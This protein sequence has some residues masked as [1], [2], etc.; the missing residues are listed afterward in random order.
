MMNVRQMEVF[1]AIMVTGSVTGAA[2]LLNV[3]QPAVS[4][5]LKHCESRLK[6]K[7]FNRVGGRLQPTNEAKAI[8]PDVAEIFGRIEAVGR[9]TQDLVGGRLGTLSV[10]AAFP[11]ANSYL[12]KAVAT[13]V[14]SRPQVRCTLQSLP[15]PQVLDRVI[16]RQ[17]EIGVGHEPIISAAVETEVLMSW[18][19]ACVMPENHPLATRSEIY[20]KDLATYPIITYL[21]QYVF[22]P[23]I[24]RALSDAGIAPN[25]VVQ[26]GVSLTGVMLARFGAGIALV[27]PLLVNVMG[28][29]G[30]V[31]RELKPR[32]GT[33][34]LLIRP[35]AAPQSVVVNDFIAHLRQTIRNEQLALKAL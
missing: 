4:T 16:N 8:F 14:A 24:D 21:P 18:S 30:L 25:I 13:F 19:V 26:V 28:I 35:K 9:L 10:A 15:T 2:Q 34:V 6:M 1:Y 12:A 22:R 17:I 11:I 31:V 32:I 23:Y 20:I 33:K 27:D 5:A 7:L 3:T 29:P